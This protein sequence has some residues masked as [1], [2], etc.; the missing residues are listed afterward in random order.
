MAPL[1]AAAG[2]H[3]SPA[4][5]VNPVRRSRASPS[6]GARSGGRG[7]GHS[8]AAV[9]RSLADPP[10]AW[11]IGRTLRLCAGE[12]GFVPPPR[13]KL[14]DRGVGSAAK[15][16][17]LLNL[18]VIYC[19]EDLC[20]VLDTRDQC[21]YLLYRN[22]CKAAALDAADEVAAAQSPSTASGPST[23]R[24]ST[25]SCVRV[26]A[27][28]S[29]TPPKMRGP[30]PADAAAAPPTVAPAAP[31]ARRDSQKRSSLSSSVR[32]VELQLPQPR[33]VEG[34]STGPQLTIEIE[35]PAAAADVAAEAAEA[36]AV[37]SAG[38]VSES[39]EEE[40]LDVGGRLFRLHGI[41]GR[42]AFGVVW[43]AVEKTASKEEPTV[44]IKAMS[45]SSED[46]FSTAIF[47]ADLLRRL[48]SQLPPDIS[49]QVPKYVAHTA[50]RSGAG[51]DVLVAM[52]YL[53]GVVLDQWLYGISDEAH[54]HVDVALAVNGGLP[55]SR[56][57]S[58]ALEGACGLAREL[59]KQLA[60]VF[61][62]LQPLALHRDVSSHNVLLDLN[63][64][65][66]PTFALI[67]F[68]LAVSS[69]TW[70][71]EWNASNLA[72]DPRCW[73]PAAWMAL[74]LGFRYVEAHPN[75]G[76][77]RQ[78]LGR[79]DH[80][81]MGILGLE[82]LFALWDPTGPRVDEAA[83]GLRRA[84]AA[85]CAYWELKF[86]LFQMFHLQGARQTQTYLEC[87]PQRPLERLAE[88]L[89]GVYRSLRAAAAHP[90]NAGR[91][92]LLRVL[93]D[94]VD[95]HGSLGWAEVKA[96]LT[97]P[98]Q[99][100]P[101][102]AGA[103]TASPARATRAR[104]PGVGAAAPPPSPTPAAGRAAVA[105]TWSAPRAGPPSH[106]AAVVGLGGR[107]LSSGHVRPACRAA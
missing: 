31:R 69:P 105:L 87:S 41:L 7:A 9:R 71:R 94:L 8:P 16:V 84:R 83:P 35:A 22:G 2:R 62:A 36:A 56:Q 15:A 92:A 72:G 37:A 63:G 20:V 12:A 25:P 82:L 90:A 76:F 51:G 39:S 43:R 104:S 89:A 70:S 55:G 33:D 77:Q 13:A 44:A 5:P 32:S 101:A 24:C 3:S 46:G 107:R 79:I 50:V 97:P 103:A 47:E 98:A 73:T 19:P 68:G 1:D 95:E 38:E 48:G 78:Y 86:R 74:A 11:S 26:R 60:G 106:A 102:K 10:L 100:P 88:L 30:S 6:V 80:Y 85:W 66:S 14:L 4:R 65:S 40:L 18:G 53:P 54:K 21:H 49:G 45:V 93:A 28:R 57:R 99:A 67:D 29:E 58:M 42:G 59:L 81:G 96:M 17:K 52:S 75:R 64:G 91:A 23:P 61:S 27:E 34:S